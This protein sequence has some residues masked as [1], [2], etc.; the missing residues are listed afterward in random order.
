M[1]CVSSHPSEFVVIQ[2]E[3]FCELKILSGYEEACALSLR[4]TLELVGPAP[5]FY[6]Q[7]DSEESAA[8]GCCTLAGTLPHMAAQ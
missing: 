4:G 8:Q 5:S 3:F 2:I 7:C 1:G 6:T